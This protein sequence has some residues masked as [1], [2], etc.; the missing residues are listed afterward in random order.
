MF[1]DARFWKTNI[2]GQK[3]KSIFFGDLNQLTERRLFFF[4]CPYQLF[5]ILETIELIKIQVS[6]LNSSCDTFYFHQNSFD[7]NFCIVQLLNF[8]SVM[9]L[10]MLF[11][12]VIFFSREDIYQNSFGV[13]QQDWWVNYRIDLHERFNDG[14]YTKWKSVIIQGT[15][16]ST[17]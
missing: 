15:C 9:K 3:N 12:F 11:K 4:I 8:T 5:P 14:L 16:R 7:E 6:I 13:W 10:M 17:S 1:F 2:T